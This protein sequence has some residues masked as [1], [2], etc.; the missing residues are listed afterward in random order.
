MNEMELPRPVST[1]SVWDIFC[2]KMSKLT[3]FRQNKATRGG[4][5]LRGFQGAFL[6]SFSGFFFPFWAI[7]LIQYQF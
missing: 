4:G 7:S 2:P 5:V 6:K 3:K 1:W